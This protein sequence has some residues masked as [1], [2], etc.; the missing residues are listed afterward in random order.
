[1]AASPAAANLRSVDL[2]YP[3][4]PAE[5]V[6]V[7]A[8]ARLPRLREL[9]LDPVG[10]APA[11]F[12]RLLAAD[13]FGRLASLELSPGGARNIRAAVPALAG[14]PGLASLRLLQ[15]DAREARPL[16]EAFA[17]AGEFPALGRLKLTS[18]TWPV[19]VA[20]AFAAAKLPRLRPF[21]A[22]TGAD[23]FP[24][25]HDWCFGAGGFG[26]RG[27]RRLLAAGPSRLHSLF[28]GPEESTPEGLR[29]LTADNFP[30]L[31]RLELMGDYAGTDDGRF[32]AFLRSADLSSLTSLKL[33]HGSAGRA[34]ALALARNPAFGNLA[35]L[36]VVV[37]PLGAAG[38][39]AL[40]SSPHLQRVLKVSA[41]DDDAAT[42]AEL[43]CD[44]T[45][46]P[47]LRAA[48][49]GFDVPPEVGERFE[50]ARGFGC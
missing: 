48:M 1:M 27:L 6:D 25:L 14:Q 20:R 36:D 41:H 29:L 33:C 23:W 17:A 30:R 24:Q 42:A 34:A 32:A 28:V 40:V 12:R 8:A 44:R 49:F 43:L 38:W 35:E 26:V 7:L 3:K 2:F 47:D 21:D 16:A 13:W 18:E 19:D 11:V 10:T 50:A 15:G 4:V 39:K 22:L 9:R 31:T 46:W 5:A 37:G 45:L